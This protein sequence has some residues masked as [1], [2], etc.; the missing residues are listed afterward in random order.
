MTVTLHTD[1]QTCVSTVSNANAACGDLTLTFTPGSWSAQAITVRA[2]TDT[3]VE[4]FHF[5]Y[6]TQ[7]V[8]SGD[9]FQGAVTAVNGTRMTLET[10]QQFAGTSLRGYLLRL[11]SGNAAGDS[12]RVWGNTASISLGGGLW[13]TVVTIQGEVET[14]PAAGD[15]A[16]INGYTPPVATGSCRA[17]SPRSSTPR[18]S[19]SPG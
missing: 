13:S 8:A 9:V 6:V 18:P 16:F 17:R 15:T 1:G 4:G 3:A 19:R 10:T 7:A 5:S 11:T 12:W 14:S 2:A